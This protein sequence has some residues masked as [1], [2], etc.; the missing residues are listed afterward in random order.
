MRENLEGREG[1][2]REGKGRERKG[3]ER[4]GLV[5][6]EKAREEPCDTFRHVSCNTKI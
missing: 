2:G 5:E 3:K 1:K 4:K 6:G